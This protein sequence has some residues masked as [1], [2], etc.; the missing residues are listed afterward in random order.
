M[1]SAVEFEAVYARIVSLSTSN[2]PRRALAEAARAE[3]GATRERS[4]DLA[5]FRTIA[6]FAAADF[7]AAALAA[8]AA[9]FESERTANPVSR[10]RALAARLLAS[11]G[12]LWAAADQVAEQQ[13]ADELWA[14]R[15][16]ILAL[17]RSNP[18]ALP[19][20]LLLLEALFASGRVVLAR[21]ALD[22]AFPGYDWT[23]E[24]LP[25]AADGIPLPSLPFLPVRVLFYFGRTAEAGQLF[26]RVLTA[27]TRRG[28]DLWV[29]LSPALGAL[30]ASASGRPDD[31]RRARPRLA[32]AFP[33]P[34]GYIVGSARA[35]LGF[36]LVAIGDY[37][38]AQAEILAGGGAG[39][40][41]LQLVDRA[42][43]LEALV[44]IALARNDLRAATRWARSLIPLTAAFAS[45]E[46]AERVFAVLDLARG[47]I[48]PARIHAD[49]AL[50]RSSLTG[51]L[52]NS[53]QNELVLAR[54]LAASGRTGDA[55][56]RLQRLATEADD[57]GDQMDRR[58]AAHELRTLGR[59]VLPPEGSGWSRLTQQERTIA[60][61]AAQGYDTRTIGAA[62]F[63]SPRTVQ[64][65]L[66]RIMVAFGVSRRSALPTSIAAL[67]DQ[68]G[69]PGTL[70]PSF[71]PGRITERQAEVARGVAA[72]L[73]N[74]EIAQRLE[75]S[76]KTVERH[77]SAIFLAW[78]VRSRTAVAHLVPH[79]LGERQP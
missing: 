45:Q 75:I 11:A 61:L 52:R 38:D 8:E 3:V 18:A 66:T 55:A 4:A 46:I 15:S 25:G 64:G 48:E 26:E 9:L 69:G 2:R 73:T 28:D 56:S 77:L 62:L 63:L 42:L 50:A 21:Q 41:R 36:G 13:A 12:A 29:D 68:T 1:R 40:H 16:Q 17:D 37:D 39:L 74:A 78:E 57:R 23:H 43:A 22:E 49:A 24:P 34:R 67:E 6:H 60:L 76:A 58:A 19:S 71:R 79:V 33:R 35:L 54:A 10:A 27:A 51:A 47:E 65:S 7:D 14:T 70:T 20:V 32:A 30:I 53:A 44:T 31:V 5:A 59:R 72:G